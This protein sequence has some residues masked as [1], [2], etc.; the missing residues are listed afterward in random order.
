[1][2]EGG[3]ARTP[4]RYTENLARAVE[5]YVFALPRIAKRSKSS[6]FS[7]LSCCVTL[8]R[9]WRPVVL[10]VFPLRQAE[11]LWSATRIH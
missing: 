11:P 4:T 1:M 10:L 5:V 3:R 9:Q 8:V 7:A 6:G 2:M